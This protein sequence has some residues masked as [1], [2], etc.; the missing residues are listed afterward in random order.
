VADERE[1]QAYKQM[2]ARLPMGRRAEPEEI[3]DIVVFAASERG[4]YLTGANIGTEGAA[5]HVV[6]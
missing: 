1:E 6:V 3:A 5:S 2:I 4:R